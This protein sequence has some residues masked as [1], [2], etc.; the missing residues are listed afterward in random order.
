MIHCI[1]QDVNQR[2][3][4]LLQNSPVK[5]D[6]PAF[7]LQRNLLALLAG[8]IAHQAGKTLC[9][10]GKGEHARLEHFVTQFTQ[11]GR[12]LVERLIQLRA[13]G[14]TGTVHQAMAGSQQLP[15]DVHQA[16]KGLGFDANTFEGVRLAELVLFW[17]RLRYHGFGV[18]M[19]RHGIR[20]R[21]SLW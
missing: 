7:D 13:V 14:A 2:F 5:F 19:N 16:I 15:G 6:L 17:R 3:S 20:Q 18:Q 1:A 21:Y 4:D 9:N 10:N 12:K 11:E 8:Q